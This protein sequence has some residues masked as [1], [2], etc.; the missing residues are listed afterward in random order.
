VWFILQY[1]MTHK[2]QLINLFSHET[3]YSTKES[4]LMLQN[5]ND[6]LF[7]FT[8]SIFHNFFLFSYIFEHLSWDF[9]TFIL[10]S[11]PF[12]SS[13]LLLFLPLF[14]VLSPTPAFTSRLWILLSNTYIA[15]TAIQTRECVRERMLHAGEWKSTGSHSD[16]I[17][18]S[19]GYNQRFVPF[20]LRLNTR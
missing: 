11:L 10:L 14:L 13:F 15:R 9:A 6:G 3:I 12:L 18:H 1:L 19:R 8:S 5:I 7:I 20:S 2:H 4:L 16:D 17:S